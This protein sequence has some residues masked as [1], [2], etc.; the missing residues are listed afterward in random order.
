MWMI[1]IA[2]AVIAGLLGLWAVAALLW[3]GRSLRWSVMDD[4]QVEFDR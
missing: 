3:L 2:V 1:L 4:D